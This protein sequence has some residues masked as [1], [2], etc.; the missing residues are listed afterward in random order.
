[1]HVCASIPHFLM[2]FAYVRNVIHALQVIPKYFKKRC[3]LGPLL[4]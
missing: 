1:M 3:S 2:F 4:E